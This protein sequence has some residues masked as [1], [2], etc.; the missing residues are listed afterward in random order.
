MLNELAVVVNNDNKANVIDTIKAIKNAGF[1]K[2][3]IQLYDKDYDVDQYTQALLCKQNDLSIIFAHLGYQK[4]NDIWTSEGE[5][6]VDR[7]KKNILDCHN[8]GI[9]MVVLH[10]CSG[11]KAPEPNEIGLNRYRQIVDYAKSLDVKVTIENTKIREHIHYL[12]DNIE[13]DNFGLCFDAGHF[14]CNFKDDWDFKKYIDRVFCVHFH[15]NNGLDDQHLLP[16]D[17]SVN[18]NLIKDRLNEVNYNG[19]V[20]MELCYR[21]DYLSM[22]IN[23]FYVEAYNRGL[24]LYEGI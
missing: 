1:K 18:W 14:H 3:F 13:D 15:D 19:P 5:Y 4:I 10:P 11:F 17:G 8:L 7:Y 22:D 12:L 23:D 9:D 16:F 21:N 2:V 24:R 20:T 6:F